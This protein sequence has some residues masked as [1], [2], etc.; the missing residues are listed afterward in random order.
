MLKIHFFKANMCWN[1]LKRQITRW[2]NNYRDLKMFIGCLFGGRKQMVKSL[3]KIWEYLTPLVTSR[4]PK[5]RQIDR[6]S[7]KT[8]EISI[9]WFFWFWN[10]YGMIFGMV[11]SKVLSDLWYLVFLKGWDSIVN[12]DISYVSPKFIQ[13]ILKRQQMIWLS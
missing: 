9:K 6:K 11:K 4:T 5:L 1:C 8:R 10:T 7:P 12:Y 2:N 13:M 3:S